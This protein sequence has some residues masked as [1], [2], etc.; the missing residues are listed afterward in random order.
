MCLLKKIFSTWNQTIQLGLFSIFTMASMV[1][2]KKWILECQKQVSR[3]GA[4]N[5]TPQ[6]RVPGLDTC[7]WH[8][9]PILVPTS[10]Q[11]FKMP[12][13]VQYILYVYLPVCVKSVFWPALVSNV[14]DVSLSGGSLGYWTACNNVKRYCTCTV[15]YCV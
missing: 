15:P 10:T 9:I 6:Y 11:V 14:V 1:A 13:H 12:K 2:M 3:A 7:F 8:V 4:S 5:Y